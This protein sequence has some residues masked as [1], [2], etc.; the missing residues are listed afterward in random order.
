MLE[1]NYPNLLAKSTLHLL[2]VEPKSVKPEAFGSGCLV[3]YQNRVF[4][5]SVAHV[6]DL[7]GLQTCIET[8]QPPVNQ[9]SPL[10]C[11]GAMS[12][13]DEYTLS[14]G[15]K[16]EHIRSV[17][18]LLANRE[19][20]LDV[21][22]CEIKENIDLLQ[23]GWDFGGVKIDAGRK[24]M[25]NLA[26]AGKPSRDKTYN[27][28]GRVR[29]EI[30]GRTIESEPVFKLGLKYKGT[31]GRFHRFVVPK[32]ITNVDDYHGC[33]GAPIFDEDG[34]LVGLA[35]AVKPGTQLLYAFS[36]EECRRLLDVAIEIGMV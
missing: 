29:Q 22:F 5:L 27:L 9:T 15:V 20:T 16:P 18:E 31:Q 13:F 36:I 3:Q 34:M 19:G 12:Y 35:S 6:T 26:E 21:T 30:K 4:L 7:S 33:S 2:M 17:E 11:V 14:K 25:L 24:V 23:P 32:L 1:L 10:Y 8:N 28:C